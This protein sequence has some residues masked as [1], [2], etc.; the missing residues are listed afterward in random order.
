MISIVWDMG[1]TMFDTYPELNEAFARVV[2]DAGHDPDM[3]EIS[4]LTRMSTDE[5][6]SGLARMY[7]IDRDLFV[8]ANEA[9]KKHWESH[10]APPRPGLD[11]LMVACALGGGLNL[12][13]THRDEV[14]AR[15]LLDGHGVTVDDMICAPSGYPRKPDPTMMRTILQRNGIDPRNAISIGD[16]PIDAQASL[17]AGVDAYTLT[18]GPGKPIDSLLDLAKAWPPK[19]PLPSVW[20]EH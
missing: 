3:E 5:A 7:T 12:V 11:E 17:A 19:K 16:R 15:S 1:G 13:V 14:S 9:L 2:S 18:S 20:Y 8:D 4:R 6:M 10:P